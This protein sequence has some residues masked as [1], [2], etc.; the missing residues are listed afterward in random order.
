MGTVT[1]SH[2][3]RGLHRDLEAGRSCD[4]GGQGCRGRA[5][6]PAGGLRQAHRAHQRCCCSGQCCWSGRLAGSR[7]G[8]GED[9]SGADGGGHPPVRGQLRRRHLRQVLGRGRAQVRLVH[10]IRGTPPDPVLHRGWHGQGAQ[11]VQG[12]V[13]DHLD[14]GR[15]GQG[16]GLEVGRNWSCSIWGGTSRVVV[17]PLMRPSHLTFTVAG[18]LG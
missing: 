15:S 18:V 2:W 16:A 7:R 1:A 12:C 4:Q 3:V 11:G 13:G 17:P 9:H 14:S 5:G 10:V 8:R 6:L